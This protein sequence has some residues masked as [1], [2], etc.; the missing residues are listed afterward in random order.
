MGPAFAGVEN[1]WR[2]GWGI[3]GEGGGDIIGVYFGLG[4]DDAGRN[5]SSNVAGQ[6]RGL[7]FE[8]QS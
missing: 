7:S 3:R 6:L 8:I 5:R 4:G 2:R 1:N